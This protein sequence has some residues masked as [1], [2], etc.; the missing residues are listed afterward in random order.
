MW[1]KKIKIGKKKEEI[2]IEIVKDDDD[3]LNC[4]FTKEKLEHS[5]IFY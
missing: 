3:D 2:N 1:R 5:S 4:G